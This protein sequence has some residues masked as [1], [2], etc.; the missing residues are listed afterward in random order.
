[1][2]RTS[3]LS[4]IAA[5]TLV[6]ALSA[7]A[8]AQARAPFPIAYVSVQKILN[9]SNDAKQG[10][11]QLEEL[12]Q[13]KAKD[14]A[15]KKQALDSTKLQIANA[16]GYFSGSKREQLQQQ[17]KRQEAEL[18]AA[19]QQAQTDFMDLQ[20]KVQ[21]GLRAELST[22]LNALAIQR[23]YQYILNQDAAI[24]LAPSGADLTK[25]VLEKLNANATERAA[26]AKK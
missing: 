25:D 2:N 17:E 24:L 19:T 21:D 9:E 1:M 8:H 23:G 11:K 22:I 12:R 16:G 13:A 3:F 20:K 6:V 15:A 10:A 7:V 26:T 18:Q 4:A 14:L 5:G